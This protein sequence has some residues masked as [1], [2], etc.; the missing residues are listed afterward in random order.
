GAPDRVLNV[1]QTGLDALSIGFIVG[2]PLLL[3]VI[4]G[5]VAWRR[6]RR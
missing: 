3:L 6:R 1:S 4:G 5:L 2:V